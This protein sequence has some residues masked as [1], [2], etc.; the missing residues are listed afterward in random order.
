VKELALAYWTM[1]G[2]LVWLGGGAL[3]M[4]SLLKKRR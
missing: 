2:S 4:D 1:A 3:S